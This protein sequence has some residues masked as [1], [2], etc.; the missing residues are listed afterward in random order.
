MDR[1][2]IVYPILFGS[3]VAVNSC[4]LGFYCHWYCQS[5]CLK[6]CLEIEKMEDSNIKKEYSNNPYNRDVVAGLNGTASAV[7]MFL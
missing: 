5:N 6:A 2:S 4:G 3:L 1:K 7:T